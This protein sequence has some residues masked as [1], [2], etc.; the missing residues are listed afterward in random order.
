MIVVASSKTWPA[1]GR[2]VACRKVSYI[3]HAWEKR[4]ERGQKPCSINLSVRVLE[5]GSRK[6]KRAG[7]KMMAAAAF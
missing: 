6:R 7:G 3:L 5:A 4:M 1:R 2:G